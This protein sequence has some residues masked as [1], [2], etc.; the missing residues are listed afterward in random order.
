MPGS[1]NVKEKEEEAAFDCVGGSSQSELFRWWRSSRWNPAQ[2]AS[3]WSL[4]RRRNAGVILKNILK[5]VCPRF[6][7]EDGRTIGRPR[8][9]ALLATGANDGQSA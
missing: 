6:S 7:G 5:D 8:M 1:W 4:S 2:A 3:V 9:L